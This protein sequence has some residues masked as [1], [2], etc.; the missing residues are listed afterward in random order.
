MSDSIPSAKKPTS[1]LHVTA[2]ESPRTAATPLASPAIPLMRSASPL[3]LAPRNSDLSIRLSRGLPWRGA[4]C[5][6]QI[7]WLAREAPPG[8]D[9]SLRFEEL[10]KRAFRGGNVLP[11]N[12]NDFV[13]LCI[14][15]I[16]SD[17][18]PKALY[19]KENMDALIADKLD[20]RRIL[21][22][23]LVGVETNAKVVR[24]AIL[25]AASTGKKV[26][27]IGH[28]KGGLDAAAALAIY[29]E[30]AAM[31]KALITMQS[32]Y[33]GSPVAQD[34][35]DDPLQKVVANYLLQRIGGNPDMARDLT[36]SQR[37]AFLAK[38]PL[39]KGINVVSLATTDRDL[40]SYNR[41]SNDYVLLRYHRRS[42][43]LTL[44][45]DC[46]LP[47]S[48]YVLVHGLDHLSTTCPSIQRWKYTPASITRALI[49]IAL[50]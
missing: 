3:L 31:T 50:T 20:V 45:V 37:Q 23:S 9:V 30:L 17:R 25:E 43:G 26:V 36:Y 40:L 12:A 46:V 13:Y 27:I 44:P 38:Y 42:D 22:D 4:G 32:P 1:S 28:S 16:F 41:P 47:D 29:P 5:A 11:A 34:I 14:G 21:I 39:P 6:E 8:S 2:G 35:A 18:I 49:T 24:E 15:G 48:R 10:N 33:A 19:L 7:G